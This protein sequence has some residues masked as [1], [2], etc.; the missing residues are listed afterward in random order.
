MDVQYVKTVLEA[1]VF[2]RPPTLRSGLLREPGCPTVVTGCARHGH[3]SLATR[4]WGRSE[5]PGVEPST[6]RTKGSFPEHVN[7][8]PGAGNCDA[9]QAAKSGDVLDEGQSL[10]CS[11]STGKP[12]TWR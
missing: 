1:P 12:C 2:K 8:N 3:A 7:L 6:Y 5:Q 4:F 9:R 11:L 10:R